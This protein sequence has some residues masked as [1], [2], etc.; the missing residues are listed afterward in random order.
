VPVGV[1]WKSRCCPIVSQNGNAYEEG[2]GDAWEHIQRYWREPS[3]E[4]REALRG[5]L[6]L[7]AI[8]SQYTDGVAHPER[9]APESYTLDAALIARP[10]N[11]EIQLDLFRDYANNVKVKL[12]PRF[13]QYF[14]AVKPPL[15]GY[16][17]HDAFLVPA[18]GGLPEDNPNARVQLLDTWHFALETHV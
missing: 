11:A 6:T 12:Y 14:R 1:Q 17:G 8:R 3:A 16:G 9:I 15:L 2:V 5:A 10:G 4:N 13:Q 7:D 18:G